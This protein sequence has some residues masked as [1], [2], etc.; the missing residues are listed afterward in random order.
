MKFSFKA[1]KREKQRGATS[2]DASKVVPKG[3]LKRREQ[4]RR[5]QKTHRQRKEAYISSLEAEVVQLRANEAKTLQETKKLHSEVIALK[6]LLQNNGIKVPEQPHQMQG[7]SLIP[8]SS[9]SDGREDSWSLACSNH[10]AKSRNRQKQIQV[11][12]YPYKGVHSSRPK[13]AS[14]LT[15]T[16][17]STTTQ[18]MSSLASLPSRPKTCLG[19]ID[20]IVLGLDFVLTLESPCLAHV[21]VPQDPS[22]QDANGH[23]L[24][25]TACLLHHHPAERGS[26]TKSSTAWHVPSSGIERLLE[27]SRDTP[28]LDDEVTPVQ[29]WDI[30]RKHE[31]F[32]G[33]EIERLE[34]LKE[35]LLGRVRCYGFGGVILREVLD[36]ALFEAFV[37]GR[38]F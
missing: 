34:S 20:P 35:K 10:E 23:A 2:A 14:T 11:Q 19:D 9:Q 8:P 15:C 38:V 27:P 26:R 25:I 31:Q 33:L 3:D 24:M 6:V 7:S 21:D 28:L 5:A 22:H 32:S 30:V 37:V 4:V 16:P 17:Y 18:A 29:A 1:Y 36:D 13:P 12:N